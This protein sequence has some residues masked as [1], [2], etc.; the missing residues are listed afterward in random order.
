MRRGAPG[1]WSHQVP[2]R[3]PLSA[4]ALF[5]GVRA[6]MGNG[7]SAMAERQLVALLRERYAPTAIVLTDSG[8]TALRTA[9]VGVLQARPGAP[10][11]L[12]A[13]SCYDLATAAE[14]AGVPVVLYDTDPHSLA[15]DLDS[16]RA[17]LRLGAAA[18]VV[19]HLYG[20]PVDLREVNRLAAEAGAVV[21]EDAAQAAGGTLSDR[22]TGTQSSLAV[23]SFGRG[24]GLTGGSGG[25]LLAHDQLGARVLEGAGRLLGEPR[26][27]WSELLVISAQL[28]LNRPQLYTFPAALPFL[29][30]GETIY[31]DPR[32][33][34]AATPVSCAVVAATWT[35]ADR[36]VETRRR[37]AEWLLATIRRGPGRAF[38]TVRTPADA[39]PGYLR[40]PVIASPD[41][42][43]AAAQSGARRLGIMP[44]YPKVLCDLEGFALRC[45]NRDGAFPGGRAL[46][47][48]LVTLPTHGYLGSRDLARLEHW[49]RTVGGR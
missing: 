42:R 22:P 3:S 29:H 8:T 28:L 46:A 34:R 39:R 38:E 6:A 25:A 31:R 43:R 32:P 16:L 40:L 20:F 23:L 35:L 18:V 45:A 33:P 48:R 37:N 36:E 26:R 2:V 11:A 24:K 47:A 10:V 15:P 41:V 13:F 27:G 5:A 9:L 49:M 7:R 17:A 14:G 19:V 1:G 44:G 4:A 21:I 30:L 12:P